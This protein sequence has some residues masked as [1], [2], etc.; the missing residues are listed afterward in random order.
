[1][2]QIGDLTRRG[3]AAV[4]GLA[5][6]LGPPHD[7]TLAPLPVQ[8]P[9][10]PVRIG[11]ASPAARR[12]AAQQDGWV[13]GC[14]DEQGNMVVPHARIAADTARLARQHAGGHQR[15]AAPLTLA[16]YHAK[17]P[18]GGSS[19]VGSQGVRPGRGGH[20]GLSWRVP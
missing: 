8:R 16:G 7:V 6:R 12:R 5:R 4:T 19:R 18:E 15:R 9:R 10:V 3:L 14:D 17:I 2:E 20:V 13:V 1:M 11:G